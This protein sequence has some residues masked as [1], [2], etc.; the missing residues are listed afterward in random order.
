MMMQLVI[1]GIVA[2][3]ILAVAAI[4]LTLTY[5]ITGFSNFS[6]GDMMT[7]GAYL[8]FF[9]ITAARLPLPVAVAASALVGAGIGLLSERVL[10][11]R[12]QR[13]GTI[14]M[15]IGSVGMALILRNGILFLFG[16]QTEYLRQGLQRPFRFQLLGQM[17]RIKPD[18]LWILAAV[19]VLGMLVHLF[20]TR[21]TPGRALRAMADNRDLALVCGIDAGTVVRW[22]WG[23]GGALA[24]VAGSLLALDTQIWPTMG[25]DQLLAIFAVTVLGGIG[26]VY[27][28]IAAA[29]LVGIAQEVSTAY[30]SGAYKPA[31]AFVLIVLALLIRPEGIANTGELRGLSA[32]W[33]RRRHHPRPLQPTP[34]GQ[35]QPDP[36]VDPGER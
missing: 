9:F 34:G 4:G 6:Y 15:L 14:M 29:F 5:Q 36:V 35:G 12:L 26:R 25:W 31:V 7:W 18:Q 13:H 10:Y 19:A 27:G 3:G 32:W 11:R 8:A 23:L 20:L 28:A 1:Y 2:G 21:S 17:L 22:T 24:A 30:I 33:A 16:P